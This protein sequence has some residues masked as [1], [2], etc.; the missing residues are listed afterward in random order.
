MGNSHDIHMD[1]EV[2]PPGTNSQ[3]YFIT[4]DAD[5]NN[6]VWEFLSADQHPK[7]N[8]S[9]EIEVH[10]QGFS[11]LKQVLSFFISIQV[12]VDYIQLFCSIF[13]FIKTGFTLANSCRL[14][15][16]VCLQNVQI[17]FHIS[18][19][20]KNSLDLTENDIQLSLPRPKYRLYST[21]Y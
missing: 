13:V 15:F 9:L 3:L 2:I 5:L 4:Q 19:S 21:N 11:L 12:G 10:N 18:P 20:F 16:A 14:C 6:K 7:S 17:P 8:F 1:I